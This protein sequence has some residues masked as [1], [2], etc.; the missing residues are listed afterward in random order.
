MS[1]SYKSFLEHPQDVICDYRVFFFNTFPSV[2]KQFY[3][4]TTPDGMM[5]L[6][7]TRRSSRYDSPYLT[8]CLPDATEQYYFAASVFFVCLIPQVI[9]RVAGTKAK[10]SFH[11]ASGWPVMSSGLGGLVSPVQWLLESEISPEVGEAKYFNAL[12]D[13]VLPFHRDELL[14]F[15]EGD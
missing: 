13:I 10:E 1:I 2:F 7:A 9:C 14:A 4:E 12:L 15:I 3:P 8:E 11:K 5:I 6:S